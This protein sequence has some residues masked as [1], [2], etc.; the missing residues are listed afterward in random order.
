MWTKKRFW[1]LCVSLVIRHTINETGRNPAASKVIL[2]NCSDAKFVKNN[3]E[4][5]SWL[6]DVAIDSYRLPS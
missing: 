5:G 1:N 3:M 2:L 6:K 4:I